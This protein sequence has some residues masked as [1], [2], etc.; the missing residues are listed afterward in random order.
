MFYELKDYELDIVYSEEDEGYIATTLE[1]PSISGIGKT[2]E[3]ALQE[4]KTAFELA[5]EIYQE[6]NREMPEPLMK[7]KYSGQFTIRLPKD[8]HYELAKASMIEQVS[9][10]QITN[11][12]LAKGIEGLY[13]KRTMR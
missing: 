5:S 3:E 4:L 11:Y 8:L 2:P 6:D 7:K 9:I 1:I 10:N 12:L 13:R